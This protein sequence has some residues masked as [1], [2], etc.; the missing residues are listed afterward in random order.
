[1]KLT[2]QTPIEEGKAL[3]LEVDKIK[4]YEKNTKKHTDKQIEK[5]AKSIQ[6]YGFNQPIVVDAENII[7]V[8]HGRYKASKF[9]GLKKVPVIKV[10]LPKNKVKAYR[11]IDNKLNESEWEEGLLLDELEDLQIEGIDL[12]ED[13]QMED[14]E[15]IE[16]GGSLEMQGSI[17]DLEKMTVS[18]IAKRIIRRS[19]ETG[20][21]VQ[22]ILGELSNFFDE[23]EDN[24]KTLI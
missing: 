12:T 11:L 2:N 15:E 20:L 24:G 8:G 7:V 23:W 18:K 22:E 19:R 17:G 5:I 21:D 6:E 9:L 16:M 1:M 3:M 10:E 14:I 13:F 4:P